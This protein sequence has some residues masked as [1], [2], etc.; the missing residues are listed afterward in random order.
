MFTEANSQYNSK[1][2]Q[3]KTSGTLQRQQLTNI[4]KLLM[5][6]HREYNRFLNYETQQNHLSVP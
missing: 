5:C 4:I 3:K 6:T 1:F 2:E